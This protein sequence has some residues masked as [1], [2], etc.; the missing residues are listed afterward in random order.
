MRRRSRSRERRPGRWSPSRDRRRGADIRDRNRNRDSRSR[1]RSKSRD[2]SSEKESD[3]DDEVLDIEPD[4]EDEDAILERRRQ[5][6]RAIEEKYEALKPP[7]LDISSMATSPA[8][9]GVS[10]PDSDLVGLQAT[11]DLKETIEQAEQKIRQKKLGLEEASDSPGPAK[12]EPERQPEKETTKRSSL[13]E[14][15]KAVRNGDMFTEEKNMF[16]EKYLSPSST[17]VTEG[18][19]ENPN[20]KDNW[21]DAEGYY[22]VRIGEQ[23]DR[24]YTVFGYTGQGVFSNVVRA[25]D[26]LKGDH[27][28]A[29]K[30]IRNNEMMHKTGLQEMQIL[31]KLNK[32]D[33]DDRFH[34]VRLYRHFFH[35]NHLCLVFETMSMNLREVLKRYGKNVGLHIKAVRS[36]AQQLLLT[37]KLMKR[38]NVLH[39]D[40]KPDNILVNETKL[41]LKMCDFGSASYSQ[42]NE[43]TPYLVSRFY[44]APEII[45]GAKYDFALDM[46]AV[47]C[48]LYE[49]YTGKILFPGKTNNEMLKLMMQIKGKMPNKLIRKGMFR[50]T[51]FDSNFAFLYRE[52][53]KVTEKEKVTVMSSVSV[54]FDLLA[55]LVGEQSLDDAH[56]RKV[57]QFKDFL[58]KCLILDPSKR[59]TINQALTHPF[60]TEKID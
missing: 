18:G 37:L 48:T 22:R 21:D 53:D 44:R 25:R 26:R 60:I 43:I 8:K 52:V 56:M 59:L 51:H 57:H 17:L 16:E 20:L 1:S 3:S 12:K 35:K 5:L 34:V 33:P 31:E 32:S 36:Y 55:A 9:S 28:V 2:K 30:I 39:A 10:S 40:I 50:E 19:N 24:R 6:R 45:I 27:E 47:G 54:T 58:E 29:I 41:V 4:S 15:K 23:L 14:M 7:Q 38:C 46:W 49:L 42:D 13:I 11:K